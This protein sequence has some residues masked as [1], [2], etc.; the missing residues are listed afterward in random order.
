MQCLLLQY[1]VRVSF[2]FVCWDS[3]FPPPLRFAHIA[4]VGLL[5]YHPAWVCGAEID[6]LHSFGD[7]RKV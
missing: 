3:T 6:L 7:A 5:L 4:I 1:D 2:L